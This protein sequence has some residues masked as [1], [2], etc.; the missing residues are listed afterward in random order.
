[1]DISD[2]PTLLFNI[3][4]LLL[5]WTL[6]VIPS[7]FSTVEL[8]N[9]LHPH[10]SNASDQEALLGFLSA[11]TAYSPSQ[12]LPTNW[13]TNVSFCEWRGIICSRRRQR[14]VSLN[15]SSMGLQGTISPLLSN[16][17]FLRIL[18][19]H[20][21]S[22]Q[23]HIP[24]EL[25][26]LFRLKTLV[27]SRNQLQG[28]IPQDLGGCRSL[29]R[30]SLYRNNFTG[31][32]PSELCLLSMLQF[33]SLG[34]N[35]L[36]GTIPGCLGNISSLHFLNLCDNHLHGSIPSELGML[37]QLSFMSLCNNHLT[38]K[39]PSSLSNSTNLITLDISENQITGR[40]PAE[41][42]SKNT[43]LTGLYQFGNQLSGS[44]P[45][46]LF[47]C[48]NLQVID[49]GRNQLS[50]VVPMQLGKLTQLQVLDLQNNQLVSGST[51]SLP[52]L[53]TLTNCSILQRID[54]SFN[55]F[56]GQLSF[57]IGHLSTKLSWI[58][59]G[60]NELG[61]EIPP[62]IGNLT[63]LTL[64]EI[65]SNS[66]TGAIP[67]SLAMLSKLERLYMGGNNFEGNI[68][69]E[70]GLLKSLGLLDLQENNL[71]GKI[72]DS[73]FD[74]QQLEYLS[75]AQNQLSGN[76]PPTLGKCMKL[77]LLD[78]SYNKLNG[79]VPPEV[80]GLVN[81]ALYFNIS[82]N[83]LQGPLPLGLSKM[84][85]LQAM[86]ISANFLTGFIPSALEQC[87]ELEYLNLSYNALEGPI[88]D[89]LNELRS[90]QDM[91]FSSNNLSGGIPMSLENLKMLSHL[92][93]SFNKLS[94][95]VPK[96]GVFKKSGATSFMGNLGLCGPW[97]SL[98]PCFPHRDQRV[99]HMEIVIIPIFVVIITMALCLWWRLNTTR[100]NLREVAASL[101]VGHQ[102]ISYGE[103]II[104]TNNFD[105]VN[106][107]GVGSFGKVYKGVLND[108]TLVAIKLLDLKNESADKSFE[109]ECKVLGKL[110]H[111]NLIRIITCYSDPQIK[112]LIF[113]FISN[114]SLEKWLHPNDKEESC[115]SLIQR[116]NIAI[117]VA[118]GLAYLHHHC[119][120]QVIHC[121]LKPS[122][123]LLG[124][125]M[126]SYL[127]DFGIATIYLANSEGST[128]TSTHALKGSMGYIPPE[129]GLSGH[130][131]TK[132]DVYSYG[133]VLLEILTG[134]KP[135]HNMFAKGINLQTWVANNFP[136]KVGE[137][138]D[139]TL[140]RRTGMGTKEDKPLHCL[141][142]LMSLGL[143]CTRE[144]PG[145]R[146]TMMDIVGKL[147]SIKDKFLEVVGNPKY[148]TDS[149]HL[150]GNTSSAY[151]NIREGQS[152]SSF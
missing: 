122:N 111:R 151:S 119:F 114:G 142:E 59:L 9:P 62:Q 20:N 74:L 67:S 68:P 87:K 55:H 126:V 132:G 47:N 148:Q 99:S 91:D 89:S 145:R 135:T 138:V 23:G 84:T 71:S 7:A 101:N 33:F 66:F 40:I 27:L 51:T 39:F 31:S 58:N 107:L 18:D 110:R 105:D 94:G 81:L 146:P 85:M 6:L 117:D 140:L 14:V 137:L 77:L 129:Y 3:M 133:I 143:L 8:S 150:L 76:I 54:L 121:D 21:N 32:I 73:L 80:G 102:R 147:L 56:T 113:P 15:V 50:G 69:M 24:Y 22:F 131:T 45:A 41:L 30:L 103:L 128:F 65:Y 26:S 17:S 35:N 57:S 109:R 46:S 88:P 75:L 28:F 19:L 108:G 100:H 12:S 139:K 70:I 112:A 5:F 104:A 134:K 115:L 152:S 43:Q 125:D 4:R 149:K 10:L 83:L 90:L 78:L 34:T 29:Q 141:S 16:L 49:L 123:V 13:T 42:C 130:V 93:L 37:S 60:S 82:N 11:I 97:V 79:L 86:D 106:L 144:S 136:N 127:I 98:S 92:N 48:T 120:V 44:I 61:G 52:I 118:Q 116:L 25:G 53:T 63:N 64:F 36:T 2:A 72:P 124:E 38:G 96:G 1:M 95:E